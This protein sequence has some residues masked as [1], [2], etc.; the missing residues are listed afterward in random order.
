MTPKQRN[1]LIFCA[2]LGLASTVYVYTHFNA[3]SI[4]TRPYEAVNQ[5]RSSQ[6]GDRD[7]GTSRPSAP[8]FS[9][10]EIRKSR[11]YRSNYY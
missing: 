1:F 10:S 2:L 8:G 6:S 5:S 9:E 3:N 4:Y 7:T 11:G